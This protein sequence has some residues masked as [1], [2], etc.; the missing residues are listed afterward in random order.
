[1]LYIDTMEYYSALK[2]NKILIGVPCL[3]IDV[4]KSFIFYVVINMLSVMSAIL[5]FVF[6]HRYFLFL[7]YFSCLPV[8]SLNFS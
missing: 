3:F 5:F 1:M 7:F 4:L 2:M 8:G 6:Y